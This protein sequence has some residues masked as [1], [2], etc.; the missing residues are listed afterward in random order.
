MEIRARLPLLRPNL[1]PVFSI[2]HN[3]PRAIA[4]A[5]TNLADCEAVGG[6][7]EAFEDSQKYKEGKCIIEKAKI[8]FDAGKHDLL[9]SVR[10]T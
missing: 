7:V 9:P 3:V 8:T 10:D 4:F 5:H 1:P 2:L 6:Q